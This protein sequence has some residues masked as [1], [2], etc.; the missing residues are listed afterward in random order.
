MHCF[1][2][3]YIHIYYKVFYDII[4]DIVPQNNPR[5]ATLLFR[6]SD[7]K[8]AWLTEFNP[9]SNFWIFFSFPLFLIPSCPH[10]AVYKPYVANQP[11]I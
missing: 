11:H 2:Y 3:I 5:Q 8:F 9:Q 10:N 4:G 7:G 6:N 1:I